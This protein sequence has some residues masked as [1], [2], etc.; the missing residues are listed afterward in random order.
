LIESVRSF[1]E[2]SEVPCL[3]FT[4]GVTTGV[5]RGVWTGTVIGIG[6]GGEI[7]E[8]K[9]D[10]NAVVELDENGRE[11]EDEDEG[12]G[13]FGDKRVSIEGSGS[14]FDAE[15]GIDGSTAASSF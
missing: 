3:L 11:E 15:G 1:N 4:T 14:C 9:V 10:K 12:G 7:N 8:G 5:T 13:A 6:V 2:L